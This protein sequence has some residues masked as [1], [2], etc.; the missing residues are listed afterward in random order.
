MK[1]KDS[2]NNPLYKRIKV[3]LKKKIDKINSKSCRIIKLQEGKA[4]EDL[5]IITGLNSDNDF[6]S[7][8]YNTIGFSGSVYGLEWD[9]YWPGWDLVLEGSKTQI[10]ENIAEFLHGYLKVCKKADE[11]GY[12]LANHIN[13]RASN[14]ILSHS[15]GTR[16][17]FSFLKYCESRN[18]DNQVILFN[19]AAP[20]SKYF[21]DF[22]SYSGNAG[23]GIINF[24]NYSD[25][26]LAVLALIRAPLSKFLE[27]WDFPGNN[28][29]EQFSDPIGL[30]E[31][32]TI[33]NNINL[34][35]IQGVEHSI[36]FL[37][38]RIITFSASEKRF[39]SLIEE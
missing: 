9:N 17:A 7:W 36:N 32:F 5:Y 38:E 10:I 12:F 30:L 3:F 28:E 8:N 27:I 31:S 33:P 16:A 20:C 4:G 18:K 29:S 24:Y 14:Y 6:N 22:S 19:G 37:V 23:K 11:A 15:M 13:E 1:T 21:F 26:V 25:P 2:I 34:N 39:I 35:R